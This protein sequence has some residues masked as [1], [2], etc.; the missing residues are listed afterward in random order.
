L[1]DDP[2]LTFAPL[3]VGLRGLSAVPRSP[4]T[5]KFSPIPLVD[6]ALLQSMTRAGPSVL[7]CGSFPVRDRETKVARHSG[8]TLL[9]FLAPTAYEVT[10]SDLRR[11]CLARLRCVSR[12]SQPPDALFPPKP[13]QFCFAP[14]TLMGFALQRFSL[15]T[16]GT[17]FGTPCPS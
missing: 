2:S 1:V 9:R 11:V 12:L 5:D 10:G 15:P 16:A 6:F 7:T 8:L 14:A 13:C 4:K 17:P 3:E